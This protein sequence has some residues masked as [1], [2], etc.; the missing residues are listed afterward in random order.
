MDQSIHRVIDA[1]LKIASNLPVDR[2]SAIRFGISLLLL[3]LSVLTLIRSGRDG[4]KLRELSLKRL[5][6][7]I[8]RRLSTPELLTAAS[9][10]SL[11]HAIQ[12]EMNSPVLTDQAIA[13]AIRSVALELEESYKGAALLRRLKVLNA[14]LNEIDSQALSLLSV[15][16]HD[17]MVA[18]LLSELSVLGEVFLFQIGLE[19]TF[20]VGTSRFHWL[21]PYGSILWILPL[22]YALT[23]FG[24]IRAGR[25]WRKAFRYHSA[26]S[27][28]RDEVV[29]ERPRRSFIPLMDFFATQV[30]S[31]DLHFLHNRWGIH[32]EVPY[33]FAPRWFVRTHSHGYF[34]IR[35]L[36]K[37]LR[38]LYTHVEL[39][40]QGLLPG[41][42]AE[43][44]SCE[45][46][47]SRLWELTGAERYLTDLQAIEKLTGSRKFRNI[48]D[49]NEQASA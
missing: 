7:L 43:L 24:N 35:K 27:E 15:A 44:R 10:R 34:E 21:R 30:S 11:A 14:A 5:R 39:A 40:R 28:E 13:E 38:P 48:Q 22:I 42:S 23:A 4:S 33:F 3:C 8:N 45:T 17:R 29:A 32:W 25:F 36:L 47:C 2:Q 49:V 37:E 18:F 41:C 31:N 26:P 20:A 1:L 6:S 19:F 16:N 46:I 12:K 9:L